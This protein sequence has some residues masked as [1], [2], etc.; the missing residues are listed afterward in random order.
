MGGC[1]DCRKGGQVSEVD[2]LR[3]ELKKLNKKIQRAFILLDEYEADCNCASY[4]K[5]GKC[6][7]KERLLEEEGK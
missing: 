5:C 3:E 7:E 2:Y 4:R 6:V 1:V